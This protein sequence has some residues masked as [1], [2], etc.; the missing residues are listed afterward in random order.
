MTG[1]DGARS[2]RLGP[3]SSPIDPD[4]AAPTVVIIGGFLTSPP[5]YRALGRRLLARGAAAVHVA[6]IWLPDWLLVVA[7]GQGPICTRAART[8]LR[9]SEEADGAPLLVI[10]HS[11]GGIV[12][13]ILTAEAPFD[14]RRFAGR[15]RI[16]AVVGLGVPHV[17]AMEEIT[18]RRS[19]VRPTRFLDEHAPGARWAPTT[20]YLS[21]ASRWLV[22]PAPG[23]AAWSAAS[24]R[25]R[26]ARW[27]Y[28]RLLAP[29]YPEVIEGD[30]LIPVSSALLPGS[31]QI[32]LD[33]AAHGQGAGHPWYGSEAWV[34]AWWPQAVE[35]WRDALRARKGRG[36]LA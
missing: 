26:A 7:R 33:G 8:V 14:G 6:P 2:M 11:A 31:R 32:I 30:G 28:E 18:A 20:G 22:G 9:A 19:G 17:N 36:P 29:P 13:R 10:G 1:A 12:A 25:E 3:D 16:G 34:D 5:L 15:G 23:T 27:R 4:T 35:T 21:V 24:R